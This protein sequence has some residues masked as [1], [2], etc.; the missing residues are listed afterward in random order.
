MEKILNVWELN[1][2]L[3][4]E[5]IWLCFISVNTLKVFI[6]LIVTESKSYSLL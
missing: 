6:F 4:K 1:K 2:L 3:D 5:L